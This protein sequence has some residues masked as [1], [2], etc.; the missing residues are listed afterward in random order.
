[1]IRRGRRLPAVFGRLLTQ[2]FSPCLRI[3]LRIHQSGSLASH[4]DSTPSLKIISNV[5]SVQESG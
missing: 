4:H 1:M 5:K 3:R 2:K